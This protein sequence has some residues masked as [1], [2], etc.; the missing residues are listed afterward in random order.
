MRLADSS[1]TKLKTVHNFVQAMKCL[2]CEKYS[3]IILDKHLG[4]VVKSIGLAKGS[5][6]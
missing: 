4:P 2:D 6:R 3:K 1:P 5:S